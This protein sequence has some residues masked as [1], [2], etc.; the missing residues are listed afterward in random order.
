MWK[1]GLT[2]G[3]GCGK[4]TVSALFKSYDVPVVDADTIAHQLTQAGQPA[5]AEIAQAFGT[6]VIK[7]DGSLNRSELRTLIFAD[8]QKKRCLET[9]LHPLIYAEMQLQINQL[10]CSYCLVSIPLL[11]ESQRT[12][13]VDRILV[14][15]CPQALQIER[16]TQ[17]DSISPLQVHAIIATQATREQ[18]LSIAD[19]IIDNSKH[20]AQLAE[21]VKK[22]HNLYLQLSST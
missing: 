10:K 3:I 22:L 4:T 20:T 7:S 1:I 13:F 5:L 9:I 14:I 2:G 21:Q 18:R 6:N 8:T 17:R 19:D 11:I 12:D 15:D 16:V